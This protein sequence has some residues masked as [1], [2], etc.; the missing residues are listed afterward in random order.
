MDS[1]TI[2]IEMIS[3][4]QGSSY[5]VLFCCCSVALNS[6]MWLWLTVWVGSRALLGNNTNAQGTYS[7]YLEAKYL[8]MFL[9]LNTQTLIPKRSNWYWWLWTVCDGERQ[10]DRALLGAN[11][12]SLVVQ[13]LLLLFSFVKIWRLWRP[14][15]MRHLI[16]IFMQPLTDLFCPVW[17]TLIVTCL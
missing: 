8:E 6:Q 15:H 3:P 11:S 4:H 2:S 10:A 7:K 16:F 17:T 1:V 9:H 14:Q 5:L 13:H 12:N